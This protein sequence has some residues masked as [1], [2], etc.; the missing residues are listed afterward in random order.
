VCGAFLRDWGLP[1]VIHGVGD[2][3]FFAGFYGDEEL[4]LVGLGFGKGIGVGGDFPVCGAVEVLDDADGD[5]VFFAV[6]EGDFEG[7]RGGVVGG[8]DTEV[9]AFSLADEVEGVAGVDFYEFIGWSVVELVFS[10]EFEGVSIGAVEA[11]AAFREGNAE[12]VLLGVFELA[13]DGDFC[14]ALGSEFFVGAA[15]GGVDGLPVG[16]VGTVVGV[17]GFGLDGGG[18]EEFDLLGFLMEEGGRALQGVEVEVVEG[19][20]GHFG[21]VHGHGGNG[22]SCHVSA[23]WRGDFIHIPREEFDFGVLEIASGLVLHGDPADDF[24]GVAFFRCDDVVAGLPCES[25]GDVGEFG[26]GFYGLGGLDFP[27][28]AGFEDGVVAEGG[29]EG[30]S[31]EAELD[32]PVDFDDG[33]LIGCGADD[34]S[35]HDAVGFGDLAHEEIDFL[36]FGEREQELLRDGIVAVVLLEN[37]Q[38]G[39]GGIAEDHG[40]W[41]EEAGGTIKDKLASA[42]REVE[43]QG[44]ADDGEV[45]IVNREAWRGQGA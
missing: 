14:G 32:F 20:F 11:D 9:G 12:V 30:F 17:D 16:D 21:F 36:S 39:A 34:F 22:H 33:G 31:G 43:R 37:A 44:I 45:L 35:P 19:F 7:F 40:I 8:V 18:A 29:K 38:R 25:T 6:A 4:D 2:F 28:E 27:D 5:G 26:L 24:E 41:L 23:G 3:A 10:G 13:G 15:E 42:G 1:S